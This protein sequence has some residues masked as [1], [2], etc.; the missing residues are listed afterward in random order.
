MARTMRFACS[1]FLT[2]TLLAAAAAADQVMLNGGR[3]GERRLL[4]P[5]AVR[6]MTTNRLNDFADLPEGIR[7]TQ[8][9][10]L[11]WRMNHPGTPGR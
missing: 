11:G 9:W 6:M 5:A 8:P 7:R 3:Y 4:S 2:L 10:G 1:S